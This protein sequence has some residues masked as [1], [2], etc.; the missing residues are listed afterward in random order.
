MIYK[1]FSDCYYETLN[2][3]NFLKK[4]DEINDS[5]HVFRYTHKITHK[6]KIVKYYGD[7]TKPASRQ[8]YGITPTG[9]PRGQCRNKNVNFTSPLCSGAHLVYSLG[10]R[11]RRYGKS[12]NI[13][14][15]A[16]RN[17]SL[18]SDRNFTYRYIRACIVIV[19]A[20]AQLR[21]VDRVLLLSLVIISIRMGFS[22]N[23]V[24]TVTGGL[25]ISKTVDSTTPG[26]SMSVV[27]TTTP[28]TDI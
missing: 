23:V 7:N 16:D 11:Q 6:A 14:T 13:D 25:A 10:S 24:E 3:K 19:T 22:G 28:R 2:K 17:A 12:W 20:R 4:C 15:A 27:N 18:F 26:G 21:G 8:M 9:S 1:Y 5:E